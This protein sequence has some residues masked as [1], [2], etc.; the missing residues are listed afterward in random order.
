MAG[1]DRRPPR[2]EER[3]ESFLG[4]WSRRKA[5]ARREEAEDREE[6][7]AHPPADEPEEVRSGQP[8]PIDPK[9]L[10]SIESL[11]A[12]SDFRI[13]MQP[14]VPGDLRAQALRRLWRLKP[15]LS[16]PDGLLEYAEDYT[17]AA[18]VSGPLK[19]AYEVGRGFV[20]QIREAKAGPPAAEQEPAAGSKVP[21]APPEPAPPDENRPEQLA[22]GSANERPP[23]HL[24]VRA[25]ARRLPRRR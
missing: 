1:P 15:S 8:A 17:D 18:R 2:P 6:A 24:P 5:E 10:P 4:R 22:A 12:D 23:G 13:F 9:L 16:E 19:T 14:G 3:G 25:K 21:P 11:T 7:L 20:E